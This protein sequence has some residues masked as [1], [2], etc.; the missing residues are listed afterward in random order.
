MTEK[1]LSFIER[2]KLLKDGD[3]VIVALSGG[4][5]SVALL[6]FL[7]SNEA[8]LNIKVSAAHVN[9]GIR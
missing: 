9:H 3:S 6:H 5:D 7:K 4:A 2:N 8:R 1:V